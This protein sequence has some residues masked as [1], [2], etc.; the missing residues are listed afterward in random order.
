MH[1]KSSANQF[2]QALCE[3]A[4]MIGLHAER[5][6]EN[7]EGPDVLWLLP[8]KVGFV[9][10][11][12]SRK[13][14]HNALT[15]E[16]HGQLHVADEWFNKNYPGYSSIRISVHPKNRATK[17]AAAGASY[18]LTYEKLNAMISDARAVLSH[19]CESKLSEDDLII[20]CDRVLGQSNIKIDRLAE[21]Y[22]CAFKE[23][24]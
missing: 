14:E 22:L 15:K 1:E 16:E 2:E 11:A 9:I 21:N 19:L 6:D 23:P 13:K 7:G 4:R 17:A 8:N 3:F 24:D 20:E 12:K 18:A 10:E 5:H